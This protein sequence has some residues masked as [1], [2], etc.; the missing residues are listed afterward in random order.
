LS[1]RVICASMRIG[2]AGLVGVGVPN[3]RGRQWRCGELASR[4]NQF[5]IGFAYGHRA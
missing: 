5:F 1:R 2:L 3:G 4:T